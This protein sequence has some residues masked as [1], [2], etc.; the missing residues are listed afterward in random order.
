M[1]NII[2]LLEKIITAYKMVK[3]SPPE[4]IFHLSMLLSKNGATTTSWINPN[5]KVIVKDDNLA[6][7]FFKTGTC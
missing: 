3:S 1:H 7:Y 4:W 6:G 2:N 5:A